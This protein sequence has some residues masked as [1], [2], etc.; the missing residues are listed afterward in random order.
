MSRRDNLQRVAEQQLSHRRRRQPAPRVKETPRS[1]ISRR[2]VAERVLRAMRTLR[3]LPDPDR[4]FF[5]M[6]N[7]WPEYIRDMQAYNSVP[8]AEPKFRPLPK[9]ISDYMTALSWTR[10][11]SYPEWKLLWFRS[12]GFSFRLIADYI[13]RSDETARRRY[14]AVI[15]DVWCAAN[16][17]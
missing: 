10:H 8:E 5:F 12:F 17:I 6:N 1:A 13:G 4:R 9:D 11:L 2:E 15:I 14:E 16:N 7:G 3:A